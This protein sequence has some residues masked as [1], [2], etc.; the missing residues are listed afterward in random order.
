MTFFAK[1]FERA[2]ERYGCPLA[3]EHT[4]RRV[5]AAS[6]ECIGALGLLE[7]ERDGD[8]PSTAPNGGCALVLVDHVSLERGEK[9][10][11]KPPAR[12]IGGLEILAFQQS[13]KKP[14]GQILR[15]V[16]VVTV[17]SQV[18]VERGPVDL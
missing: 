18:A 12:R 11:A 3:I 10:S 14:L 13:R 4:F 8:V 5:V 9:E 6:F 2:V 17:A 7:I 16:A 15:F 1:A